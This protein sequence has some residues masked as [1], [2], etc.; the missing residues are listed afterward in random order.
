VVNLIDYPDEASARAAFLL[1]PDAGLVEAVAILEH[2]AFRGVQPPSDRLVWVDAQLRR[3]A[4]QRLVDV[5]VR[6][7]WR[8]AA[9]VR[10][11]VL[12]DP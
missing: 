5:V 4:G 10:L 8:V 12:G 3:G 11:T 9:E 2:C 6:E 1:D 7:G